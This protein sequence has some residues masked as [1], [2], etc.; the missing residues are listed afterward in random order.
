MAFE[1]LL[2]VGLAEGERNQLTIQTL[3]SM[4]RETTS[5]QSH[6]IRAEWQCLIDF[7]EKNGRTRF[8]RDA[9]R[10]CTTAWRGVR[11]EE[12]QQGDVLR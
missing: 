1:I 12:E 7:Q 4:T 9:N 8:P 3:A 11:P 2:G 10:I 6:R 5:T